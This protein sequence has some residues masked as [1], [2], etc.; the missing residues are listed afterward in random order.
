[1]PHLSL[2]LMQRLKEF[3]PRTLR[4]LILTLEALVAQ[5]FLLERRRI[6]IQSQ[7][8]HAVLQ[9]VLL[10]HMRPL[11]RSVALWLAEHGLHFGRVDQARDVG[12][13]DEV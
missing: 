8:D 9:R 5:S 3:L 1:M 11:R 13:A 7:H 2:V 4:L 6:R 10:L 12:V